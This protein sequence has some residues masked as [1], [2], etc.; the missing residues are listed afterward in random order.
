[1]PGAF[2]S[3]PTPAWLK[4]E[5]ASVLDS[6]LVKMIRSL[7]NAAP[8]INPLRTLVDPQAQVMALGLP[9]VP[10]GQETAGPMAQA[11]R[12]VIRAFH[13]SPHDFDQ[14]STA[15]IGT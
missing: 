5:N 6:P 11:L 9:M 15:K 1:M 10:Q 12:K 4:P 8:T 14:F 2:I 13:G 3:D 7:V